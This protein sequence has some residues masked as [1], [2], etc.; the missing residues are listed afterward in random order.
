MKRTETIE[1]LRK[2]LL[3]IVDDEHS[4][5][6]VAAARQIYC[7]GFAQWTFGELKKRYPMIVRSRPAITP[8]E[9]RELAN[10]WQLARQSAHGVELACDAQTLE[11]ARSICGGWNQWSDDDLARFHAELL[12]EAVQVV[13]DPPP[14]R[15]VG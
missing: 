13:P 1:A 3:E 2:R 11:G 12:G 4:M 7:H 10:R 14:A 15:R 9:L 8:A 6:E 5:C